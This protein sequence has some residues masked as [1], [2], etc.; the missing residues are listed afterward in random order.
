MATILEQP[1]TI[2]LSPSDSQFVIPADTVWSSSFHF[3]SKQYQQLSQPLHANFGGED[4]GNLLLKQVFRPEVGPNKRRRCSNAQSGDVVSPER[5]R[6]L[7]RNRA[8]SNKCRLKK[9]HEQLKIQ[10]ALNDATSKRNTLLA[11]VNGLKED[12]WQL[13]NRVFAHA[14]CGDRRINLQLTEMTQKLLLE[15]SSLRRPSSSLSDILSSDGSMGK[16]TAVALST[17]SP[18]SLAADG[19][20]A[21]HENN[22]NASDFYFNLQ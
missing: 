2:T 7:E 1:S 18:V 11:E 4:T 20:V 6:Y 17:A 19:T 22:P 5:A 15:W 14:K 16:G 3:I 12:V 13:K 9:K 8:A 10:H 21:H